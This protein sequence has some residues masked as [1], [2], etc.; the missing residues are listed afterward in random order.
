M[1]ETWVSDHQDQ[2]LG[3]E[4]WVKTRIFKTAVPL[5]LLV[6]SAR[7]K[8]V[9]QPRGKWAGL[10]FV[11]FLYQRPCQVLSDRHDRD[12][13]KVDSNSGGDRIPRVPLEKLTTINT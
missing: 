10:L 8:V 4:K 1:Y 12:Y 9:S 7:K 11:L 13:D 3:E 6:P 5:F 2:A